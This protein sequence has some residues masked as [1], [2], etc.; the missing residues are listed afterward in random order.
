MGKHHFHCPILLTLAIIH[1]VFSD[2]LLCARHSWK[3]GCISKQKQT[4]E[5]VE[6]ICCWEEREN[7]KISATSVKV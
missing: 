5:L 7:K 1:Q 6:L 2:Y 4:P 3:L